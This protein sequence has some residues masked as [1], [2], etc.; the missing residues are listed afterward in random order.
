M[1]LTKEESRNS[2]NN[3]RKSSIFKNNFR[4]LFGHELPHMDTVNL[5]MHALDP[6]ELESVKT[7]L[8]QQL[9]KKKTFHSQRL[10]NQYYLVAI[11][12]TWKYR[13]D[14]E[15][16]AQC[17]FRTSKT[18]AV[19]FLQPVL[20]A[21]L[22]GSNGMSLSLGTEWILNGEEYDPCDEKKKQDC[23]Q[24]AFIRL[25]ET[26]KKRHP[27]LPICILAD[28]LYP[29]ATFFSLCEQNDWRFIVTFKDGNLP[30]VWEEVNLLQ[31]IE[32]NNCLQ[33]KRI[34]SSSLKVSSNYQWHN[35][36]AYQNRHLNWMELREE[37]YQ[38]NQEET[39]T[40]NHFV[41]LTDFE[42]SQKN[43]RELCQAGRT[44]W[45]IENEGFN[46]QKNQG[47]ALKHKFSRKNLHAAKNYHQCMNIAHI[48]NQLMQLSISF[49]RLLV[50]KNT[51]KEIWNDLKSVLKMRELDQE[52]LQIIKNERCRIPLIC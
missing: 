26:L 7:W 2:F 20:E 12:A 48:I 13:F 29:N 41:Y 18:G 51:L 11:D 9:F 37:T 14:S 22:V 15:P 27:H 19:S 45:R 34:L 23:E 25:A 32:Q 3:K 8:M 17:P 28:G 44:R 38:R 10:F 6:K 16:Y 49:Q 30:S 39:L 4:K 50:N 21:H 35:E 36:I 31:K 5:A 40:S 43:V 46:T 1:F 42:V 24:K 47:Y 33:A 52:I